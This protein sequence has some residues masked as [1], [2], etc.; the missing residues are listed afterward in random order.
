MSSSATNSLINTSTSSRTM[1]VLVASASPG[2]SIG[3]Q[4]S[5]HD[6]K[7]YLFLDD[8]LHV[9]VGAM[10]VGLLFASIFFGVVCTKALSYARSSS[11]ANAA[12]ANKAI[13][14]ALMILNI[15]QMGFTAHAVCWPIIRLNGSYSRLLDNVCDPRLELGESIGKGSCHRPT[16]RQCRRD[17]GVA[18]AGEFS[19]PFVAYGQVKHNWILTSVALLFINLQ[20][21]LSIV[22][23]VQMIHKSFIDVML[24]E[25][26]LVWP[27]TT[28]YGVAAGVDIVIAA[29]GYVWLQKS[30][31]KS[32]LVKE[33]EYWMFKSLF[34][35][36]I[37]SLFSAIAVSIMSTNFTWLAVTFVLG[38]LY[39]LSVLLNLE[40]VHHPFSEIVPSASA[41]NSPAPR[42]ASDRSSTLRASNATLAVDEGLWEDILAS[43]KLA[44]VES[45]VMVAAPPRS[46]LTDAQ[47]DKKNYVLGYHTESTVAASADM[48]VKV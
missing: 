1:S 34:T 25:V 16:L 20:L 2:P 42:P 17:I 47:N 11:W 40:E 39:T 35:C 32:K 30:E 23:L 4:S 45:P 3:W 19:L 41:P 8:S 21:A 46:G 38:N 31:D 10:L 29:L 7:T 44:P 37:L 43:Q 24:F 14:I 33:T 28:T 48:P 36:G 15:L 5:G 22:S 12:P 18:M 9:A 13:V 26:A 27:L 6:L